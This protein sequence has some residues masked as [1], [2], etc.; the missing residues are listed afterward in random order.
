M[1]V[2]EPPELLPPLEVEEGIEGVSTPAVGVPVILD[3]EG[4]LER[5]MTGGALGVA[6]GSLPAAFARVASNPLPYTQ[7][8]RHVEGQL[9]ECAY[10]IIQ[11]CP[12]WG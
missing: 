6:S 10:C 9:V 5:E 11:V 1:L 8:V 2:L 3:E 7:S 4:V 12:M